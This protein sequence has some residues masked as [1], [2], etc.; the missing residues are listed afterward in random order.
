MNM[1]GGHAAYTLRVL[2]PI[3]QISRMSE[4]WENWEQHW[5]RRESIALGQAFSG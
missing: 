3:P 2:L 4:Q 1:V 5:G